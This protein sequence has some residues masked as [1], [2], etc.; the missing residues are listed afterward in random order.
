MIAFAGAVGWFMTRF[1]ER[2]LGG[3]T[4][5]IAGATQQ[6]AEIAALIGLLIALRMM[7]T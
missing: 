5:D 3:Q 7:P 4:G 6:L 2:H 1:A